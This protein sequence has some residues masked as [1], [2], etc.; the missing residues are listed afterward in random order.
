MNILA[1]VPRQSSDLAYLL[2][3]F[4]LRVPVPVS[5]RRPFTHTHTWVTTWSFS[6]EYVLILYIYLC[7]SGF[8]GSPVPQIERLY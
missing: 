6:P 7:V 2:G 4:A 8:Q 5:V 1:W 3:L